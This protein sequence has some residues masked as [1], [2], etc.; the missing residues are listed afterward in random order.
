MT[1]GEPLLTDTCKDDKLGRPHCHR[2]SAEARAFAAR[3]LRAFLDASALDQ[4]I[5]DLQRL[6][7]RIR[8]Q[9]FDR[10]VQDDPVA[11]SAEVRD[12]MDAATCLIDHNKDRIPPSHQVAEEYDHAVARHRE[13]AAHH[14]RERLDTIRPYVAEGTPGAKTSRL[15]HVT[16][17]RYTP[18]PFIP[19]PPDEERWERPEVLRLPEG[20]DRL[21][22]ERAQEWLAKRPDLDRRHRCCQ[23]SS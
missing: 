2:P 9:A 15:H 16:C 4:A 1:T 12:G 18:G 6:R 19:P 11:A 21:T 17:D 23:T 14:E 13:R 10:L 8:T 22:P 5:E 20:K 3:H 7:R